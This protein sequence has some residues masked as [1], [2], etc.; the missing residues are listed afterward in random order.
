MRTGSTVSI[1]QLKRFGKMLSTLCAQ[2]YLDD[3]ARS[4]RAPL[5]AR[6]PVACVCARVCEYVRVAVCSRQQQKHGESRES[7]ESVIIINGARR[8]RIQTKRRRRDH[9]YSIGPHRRTTT[10]T[11]Q[12]INTHDSR[13][14]NTPPSPSSSSYA[15]TRNRHIRLHVS[16]A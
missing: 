1:E 10:T 7:R 6:V 15:P 14:A 3:E 5:N 11:P 8:T 16:L 12:P 4:E 9:H 13:Q 2:I